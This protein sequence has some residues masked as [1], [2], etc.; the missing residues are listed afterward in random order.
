MAP[1]AAAPAAAGARERLVAAIEAVG[2]LVVGFSGGAD[3]ALL[4]HAA[5]SALGRAA[6]TC[7]TA[8]SPSLA[9][10]ELA[11]CQ[12]LAVEWDLDWKSVDT[13]E[14]A[15][16]LY[17]ANDGSRCYHCKT[18]LMDA[19]TPIAAAKG[20]TVALGV[21]LDDLGDY[22]PG[23]LAATERGAVFPLVTAGLTKADVRGL[24]AELGLRTAD[25]PAAACLASRVPYGTEVSLGVLT[26]VAR[27]ES[28]LKRLGF[29]DVRV[30]H[31][32]DLARVEVPLAELAR[33]LEKRDE[34]VAAVRAAGY[35]YVTVDW[36]GLRSGNLNQG[37][38]AES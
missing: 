18:E 10:E 20:A 23:Q 25:K 22:R 35:R 24:S 4:A 11:D 7:V 27:A 14:L 5:T 6:V 19:L 31:Y 32:G 21:N 34:V 8:V 29:A 16:P 15:N 30:R 17:A 28:G 12:A 13:A 38:P 36:E 26:G 2:P 3:S 33:L 1:G 37:L 9:P